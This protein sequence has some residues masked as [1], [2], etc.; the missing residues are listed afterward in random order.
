MI[1]KILI[2]GFFAGIVICSQGFSST[3]SIP[4]MS[5]STGSIIQIPVEIDDASGIAGFQLS[6]TFN[7]NILKAMEVISGGLTDNWMIF[8]NNESPGVLSIV[9]LNGSLDELG[10]QTGS[11][12]FIS[13]LV[14]GDIGQTSQINFTYTNFR[15]SLSENI[16]ISSQSGLFTVDVRKGDI[17]G[18]EVVDISDVIMCLRMA[19]ELPLTIRQQ[20][21][22]P[23]YP[24]WLI[25]RAD[26]NNNNVIDISDVI[27]TLR[28]AIGLD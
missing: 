17:N 28:K 25:S 12:V 20:Q 22:Q 26:M 8:Y 5:G 6:L 15:N 9:A 16:P 23:P 2:S 10:N 24:A 18:D 27:L 3:V 7:E 13:F 21:Y 1:K 11:L 19:I 4:N 14:K